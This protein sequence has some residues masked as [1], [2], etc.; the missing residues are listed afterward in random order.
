MVLRAWFFALALGGCGGWAPQSLTTGGSLCLW[1]SVAS[2]VA[3]A[4]RDTPLTEPESP[5]ALEANTP[6]AWTWDP[7]VCM[8]GSCSANRVASGSAGVTGSV[9]TVTT[10]A[11]WDSALGLGLRCSLDCR[12][13]SALF[14]VPALAPGTYTLK[15]GGREASLT[16]PSTMPPCP[17]VN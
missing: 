7:E 5:V 4:D 8:S 17:L 9:I 1:G 14:E 3:P 13:P 16:V 2:S 11:T 15:H 6:T 12:R 10:S